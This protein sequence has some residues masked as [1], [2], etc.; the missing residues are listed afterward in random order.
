MKKIFIIY[1][2]LC[3]NQNFQAQTINKTPKDYTVAMD[4]LF[5]F[6]NKDLAKTGILYD[7]VIANANLVE[8]NEATSKKQS[9]YWH[10]V[11]AWGEIYRASFVP[12]KQ[13]SHEIINQTYNRNDNVIDIGI[14]NTNIN[15]LDFGT[16]E[17]PNINFKDG[18]FREIANKNPFKEKR[19]T[20]VACLKENISSQKAKF[21][22]NPNYIYQDETNRIRNLTMI[23]EDKSLKII[24][25]FENLA[26]TIEYQF[27]KSNPE[28]VIN[29]K[30]EYAD[31]QIQNISSKLSVNVNQII[32]NNN[33]GCNLLI[34]DFVNQTGLNQGITAASIENTIPF[35]GYNETTA[36]KGVLEYR[37]YYS[38][39]TNNCK[40]QKPVI[41][42]DGFDPGDKR[43]IYQG[44]AG[45]IRESKSLYELMVYD[46]DNVSNNNNN[47]N[48]I[49]DIL[50]PQG[51]DVTLV[52][53]P[54]GA[55]YV[56][57]NA[58]ALVALLKR[59][60]EKLRM[61]GSTEQITLVGPSMGG[62][63]SR[64][65]LAYMEKNNIPHNVK[66]WVS[67]DSPHLGAN[68]PIAAQENIYFF[69]HFGQK[70]QAKLKFH[71]NFASPAARQML[72][73]Q[74]DFAHLEY[75]WWV[76]P[77]LWQAPYNL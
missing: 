71:E 55:D 22:L 63:V 41:I 49:D 4:S 13:P 19:T 42:I 52:N 68:I 51:F 62:L 28:M 77:N 2:L 23:L 46:P 65:A 64:Y 34:E 21:R 75:N 60:N 38:T 72:I 76:N 25:N 48:F 9:D 59:E 74:M 32:V 39:L 29:F 70:D 14:I 73:E 44:S 11:Q 15:Y 20:I 30:V 67:F 58:M 45:W 7:R 37:T 3:L 33:S 54:N 31:N 43:K 12:K 50:L 47:K 69:G 26:E 56:E 17:N 40:L 6:L 5:Q 61:N 10:F 53:F 36:T 35:Q 8:F 24:N 27:Q 57:R 18:F 16:K 66:L 1:T